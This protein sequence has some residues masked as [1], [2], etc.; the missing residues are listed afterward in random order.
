M[1]KSETNYFPRENKVVVLE[2]LML[3]KKSGLD[4]IL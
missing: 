1:I 4:L 2:E 3:L